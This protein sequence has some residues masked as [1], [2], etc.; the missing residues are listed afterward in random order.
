[1][2]Q[3]GR[4]VVYL[5]FVIATTLLFANTTYANSNETCDA[6]FLGVSNVENKENCGVIGGGI[7]TYKSPFTN[8]TEVEFL[9]LI[10]LVWEE[11]YIDG[12]EVGLL[13]W[14]DFSLS[15]YSLITAF[16]RSASGGYSVKDEIQL[17]GLKDTDDAIEAGVKLNWGSEW[18]EVNLSIAHDISSK[19]EGLIADVNYVYGWQVS[20]LSI[21]VSLSAAFQSRDTARHYYGVNVDQVGVNR[22]VYEIGSVINL[23][24]GYFLDKPITKEWSIIHFAQL[25]HYADDIKESPLTVNDDGF[26]AG[27]GVTYSF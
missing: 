4:R 26:S 21:A 5:L 12:S 23:S 19:H 7:I 18:G 22:P 20:D 8:D 13:F 15:E 3:Q 9:P 14:D 27:L 25:T 6:L 16:V 2:A 24:A 17:I 10:T 1:M 11:F